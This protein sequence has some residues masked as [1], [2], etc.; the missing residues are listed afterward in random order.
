MLREAI[1]KIHLYLGLAASAV[2]VTLGGTGAVLA[3]DGYYD[4]WLN[5]ALW[6]VVPHPRVVGEAA[7]VE[8]V[9]RR[10]PESPIQ[11]IRL[12]DMDTAQV[13][14][15]VDRTVFVD[16]YSG[17]ILG[18]R[19]KSEERPFVSTVR[20]I[21]T[22]LGGGYTGRLIV[23]YATVLSLLLIP[24]GLCVWWK[25]KTWTVA[26]GR[27]WNRVNWDLHSAIGLYSV[28]LLLVLSASGFFLAFDDSLF[29]VVRSTPQPVPRRVLS[30]PGTS[31]G[32]KALDIGVGNALAAADRVFPNLPTSGIRFPN[33]ETAPYVVEKRSSEWIAGSAPSSVLLD[34]YSGAVLRVDDARAFTRGYRAYRIN[35]ALHT[36]TLIGLPGRVLLALASLLLLVLAVSGALIWLRKRPFKRAVPNPAVIRENEFAGKY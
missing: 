23:D 9:A 25:K 1:L 28:P 17:S 33:A 7:L 13:F 26:W 3:F 32:R 12:G 24:T 6:R 18:S 29:W 20:R 16:P 15:L 10:F 11:S 31:S 4:R 30:L 35:L 36:G 8:T 34:R 2:L 5:P 27:S 21:H 14:A 19:R 22:R